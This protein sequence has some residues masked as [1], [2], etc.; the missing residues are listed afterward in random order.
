MLTIPTQGTKWYKTQS[1]E[2]CTG[3]ASK[4]GITLAQL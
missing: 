2:T 4:N 3:V 1:G